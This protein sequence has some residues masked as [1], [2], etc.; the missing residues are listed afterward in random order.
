[1]GYLVL[2]GQEFVELQVKGVPPE[3]LVALDID[4]LRSNSQILALVNE[5]F[6]RWQRI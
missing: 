1:M 4:E 2:Y 6:G 5:T 3:N